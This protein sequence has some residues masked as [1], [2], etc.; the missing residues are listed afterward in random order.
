MKKLLEEANGLTYADTT[1]T[2]RSA[3]NEA[4]LVQLSALAEELA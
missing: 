1:V 3:L 2:I 4:S